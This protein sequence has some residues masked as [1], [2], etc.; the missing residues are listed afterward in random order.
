M[1]YGADALR[2]FLCSEI[3]YGRDGEFSWQRFEEV[4]TAHLANGLGNLLS[5]S[6]GMATKY[7]G[8]VPA[9]SGATDSMLTPLCDEVRLQASE[10][11]ERLALHEACAQ[12]WRI[13]SACNEQIQA[14]EPWKM[15]K[16]ET[17]TPELE[18]FLYSLLEALRI[19]AILLSP[20]LPTK[21]QECLAALGS[22]SLDGQLAED[23]LVW[24]G[25]EAGR[26]LERPQPL[27]PRL[28]QL[29]GNS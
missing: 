17:R 23:L 10:A 20:I 3:T 1:T 4:Y 25:L 15:A 2:Y 5:R 18:A 8:G 11:Y 16:D 19:A 29:L 27:F 22:S 6:I 28:D 26:T 12:A 7:F 13:V 24:G 14:R 21:T 9:V